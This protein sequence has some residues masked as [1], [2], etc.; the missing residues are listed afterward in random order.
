MNRKQV[1]PIKRTPSSADAAAFPPCFEGLREW[2]RPLQPTITDK[3]QGVVYKEFMPASDLNPF[4]YCYW[5]L[6]TNR[7]L[8]QSFTYRVVADG[9]IDIFFDMTNLPESFVMGFSKTY[10]EFPIGRSFRYGGIRFLP[11]MFT[12]LYGVPASSLTN[13]CRELSEVLPAVAA[14]ITD[15][16]SGLNDFEEVALALDQHILQQVAVAAFD[17]DQRLYNAIR[18]V[19]VESGAVNVESEFDTGLS[20]RQLRRLSE[21]YIGVSMKTFAKVIRFQSLLNA[22]PST[23]SLRRSKLFID[24]GY[25]DQAHFIKEF[26]NFYGLTPSRAFGR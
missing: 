6:K 24:A 13:R 25:Y 26:R 9:C 8:D 15:S 11:T 5:E 14:F 1:T 2:Y 17:P 3:A 7:I 16:L 21:Y 20:T 12:Q 18:Q 22:K 4:I 10:T 23:E 19:L